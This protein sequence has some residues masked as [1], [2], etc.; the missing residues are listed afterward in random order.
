MSLL[1]AGEWKENEARSSIIW[2]SSE[3][4]FTIRKKKARDSLANSQPGDDTIL[5]DVNLPATI[6]LTNGE[7]AITSNVTLRGPGVPNYAFAD[8]LSIS[9]GRAGRIFNVTAASTVN[10]SRNL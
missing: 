10:I 7:I 4:F 9:G 3:I 8:E 5:F 1:A 6:T 2:I